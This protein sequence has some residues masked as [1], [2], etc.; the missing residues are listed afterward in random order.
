LPTISLSPAFSSLK[1]APY[2]VAR[3]TIIDKFYK[4]ISLLIKFDKRFQ[5]A[6]SS[7]NLAFPSFPVVLKDLRKVT[8]KPPIGA[9][10]MAKNRSI[11]RY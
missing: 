3:H 4:T 1:L 11:K 9:S 6:Q 7:K 8:F 10:G 5:G 2:G